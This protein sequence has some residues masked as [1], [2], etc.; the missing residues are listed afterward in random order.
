MALV[1]VVYHS[2]LKTI[3]CY[4]TNPQDEKNLFQNMI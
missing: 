3:K 4:A 1:S 2:T